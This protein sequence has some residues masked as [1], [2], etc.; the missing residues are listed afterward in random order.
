MSKSPFIESIR[1]T[2]RTKRYSLRTEK[3]YL[4]WIRQFIIFH[5]KRHPKDMAEFEVEQF[6]TH[7][8]V[9]KKVSPL[10]QNQALCALIFMFRHEVSKELHNMQFQFAKTPKRIPQ[11][12][13][14]H[15]SLSVIH[16]LS[17][18]HQLVAGLMYG[19][20]L[21]VSEALRLR[22][23]DFDLERNTV[24]V[25]RSKGQKDRMT[26]LPE[27]L[28]E[29]IAIQIERVK[30]IHEQDLVDGFG[31]T[32]LPA[33]LIKKYGQAAKQLYWQY[34]F[35]STTRCEHPYDGY[36]CRHH[37]HQTSFRKA[38]KKA[39][40]RANIPKRVTSHT[41]RH[42][43]A[44]RML[45]TGH[46]IRVVQELLGHD[47]VKTTQI[48]THVLGKNKFGAISPMDTNR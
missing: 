20:G 27:N 25:F 29:D 8:A 45:E 34:L 7:L 28:K 17:G 2:I 33:S 13:T 35:P 36:T 47:D 22:I 6:L 5:G 24:F 1:N 11:V 3:A 18:I 19:G 39:V 46:D 14:H 15:E 37:I 44:T 41:F 43:F 26:L 40:E 16:Q 21:R 38:L 9:T 32:S 30:D 31:M 12:L 10:T 42:S 23:K 4:Y 48:Y